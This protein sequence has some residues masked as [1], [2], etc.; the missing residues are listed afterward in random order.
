MRLRA[1]HRVSLDLPAGYTTAL[2]VLRGAIRIGEQHTVRA[3]ELAVMEPDGSRLEFDVAEDTT[4]LLLNG[5]P[6]NEPV[7]GYGPFVMNS[8]AEI[9][10][11]INDFNSGH[12]GQIGH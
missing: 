5:E 4:L 9:V 1:G 8:Q 6:L 12:F 7:V 2:F 3:A 10:Q 11:A